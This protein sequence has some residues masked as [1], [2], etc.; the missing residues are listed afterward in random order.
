MGAGL[1]VQGQPEHRRRRERT[2]KMAASQIKDQRLTS[3]VDLDTANEVWALAEDWERTV[4]WTLGEL[5]RI[6]LD[7]DDAVIG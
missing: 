6:G 2:K 7:S 3:C 1:G 5:I 4:S